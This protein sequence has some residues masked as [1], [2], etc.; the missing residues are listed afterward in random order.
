MVGLVVRLAA[1]AAFGLMS[2]VVGGVLIGSFLIMGPVSEAADVLERQTRFASGIQSAALHAK[3]IANDERGFLLSG[4][5]EF[6]IEMDER[7]S[8]A[9]AALADALDN[10]EGEQ[11]GAVEVARAGFERWLSAVGADVATFRAGDRE[12]ALDTSLGATRGLRKA[13][14]RS[15]GHAQVLGEQGV[16]LA[17]RSM[18]A[19]STRSVAVLFGYLVIAIAVGV[20]VLGWF[21]HA[22]LRP[23][24]GRVWPPESIAPVSPGPQS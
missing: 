9:R 7:K 6:L 8:L 13:Y 23:A 21:V 24:Y 22:V 18:S 16:L 1:V 2:L 12:A 11:V 3:G 5:S 17:E 10:A 4:S 19:A 15:L 14:E 20:A